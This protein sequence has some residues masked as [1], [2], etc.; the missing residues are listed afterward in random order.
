MIRRL[1]SAAGY[2]LNRAIPF[3]RRYLTKYDGPQLFRSHPSLAARE[4]IV[5]DEMAKLGKR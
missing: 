1:M 5:R 4:Q 2:D 3:W